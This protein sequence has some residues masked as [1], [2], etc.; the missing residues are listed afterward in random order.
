MTRPHDIFA[1]HGIA[2]DDIFQNMPLDGFSGDGCLAQARWEGEA[3]AGLAAC[4]M[5]GLEA[6]LDCLSQIFSHVM[7]A[8]T[9]KAA[10]L[11]CAHELAPFFTISPTQAQERMKTEDGAILASRMPDSLTLARQACEPTRNCSDG[12][13]ADGAVCVQ[14]PRHDDALPLLISI[15]H[16]GR[17]YAKALLPMVRLPLKDLRRSE[18]AY[19]DCLFND[20]LK[21]RA[22]VVKAT[23]PRVL[24]DVNREPFELDPA[25]FADSL[26]LFINAG[27]PRVACGLG[28]IAR[29]VAE[30]FPIYRD[31]LP[32]RLFWQRLAHYYVP[33]Y[34]AMMACIA[35]IKRR[36]GFCLVL[37]CH[38]MPAS[39][40]AHG[41]GSGYHYGHNGDGCNGEGW[42]RDIILGNRFGTSCEPAISAFA[43]RAFAQKHYRVAQ[44]SPYAGG[45]I[46]QFF[47]N[48]AKGVH[49]LQIELCRALYMEEDGIMLHQGANIL[50]RDL[51][52]IVLALMEYIGSARFFPHG[53]RSAPTAIAAE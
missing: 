19:V 50:K 14:S 28:T 16:A 37:D 41:R 2:H 31:K 6:G 22:F 9:A 25:M 23:F 3:N 24:I 18:D 43:E 15:P 33:Y 32:V 17:K 30:G 46:T 52:E 45:F 44:N 26:P 5:P 48:P 13:L 51:G 4:G 47:G 42:H 10:S 34:C 38:S 49:V 40:L 8:E 29:I 27:S 12:A 39:A 53:A 21:E 11:A 20:V 1:A 35:K 36:F 7:D